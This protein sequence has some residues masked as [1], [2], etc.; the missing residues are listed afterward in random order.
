M[1][2]QKAAFDLNNSLR[3][4]QMTF[5]FCLLLEVGDVNILFNNAGIMIA[6]QFLQHTEEEITRIINVRIN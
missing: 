4:P 2:L 3:K 6:K 1:N 5:A